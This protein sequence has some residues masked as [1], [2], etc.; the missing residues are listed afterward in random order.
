MPL[1]QNRRKTFIALLLAVLMI[2]PSVAS[3]ATFF[4]IRF[5]LN[6][7]TQTM[8]VPLKSGTYHFTCVYKDG[9]WVLQQDGQDITQP[10]VPTKPSVPEPPKA[11][12]KPTQP[13]K[14]ATPPTEG[15]KE[16]QPVNGLTA[17]EQKMLELINAERKKAGLQPLAVDMRLVT[18]SRLKSKDMI[19]KNYFSHTS[20]TYGSPFDALKA[21]GVTYRYAGENL[22]GASTVERAHTNLMNSPGHRANILNPNYNYVGIGIVDGGPYGKMFTQTF[23]GTK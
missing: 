19:D 13:E 2:V 8:Q 7:Q 15:N 18:I 4:N 23:I 6:G 14:P 16:N 10:T 1:R 5:T 12:P 22:A 17:D 9:K 20:P 11:E 3:A 21:N